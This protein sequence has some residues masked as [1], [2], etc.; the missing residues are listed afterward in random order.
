MRTFCAAV[1]ASNGGN[2]GLAMF[3]LLVF[4]LSKRRL[5]RC[6]RALRCGPCHAA[7]DVRVQQRLSV[8]V[9]QSEDEHEADG[10]AE[11]HVR[12]GEALIQYPWPGFESVAQDLQGAVE[13]T[14]AVRAAV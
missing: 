2:G 7:L 11:Q 1:L 13:I 14:P 9:Q 6:E 8:L 10:R 3:N 12:R 5:F 4:F